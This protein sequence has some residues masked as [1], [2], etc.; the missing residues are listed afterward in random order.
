M[1]IAIFLTLKK[2]IKGKNFG[3]CLLLSILTSIISNLFM[4]LIAVFFITSVYQRRRLYQLVMKGGQLIIIK[5]FNKLKSQNKC[6]TTIGF[7]ICIIIWIICGY[8]VFTFVAV[9]QIQR[10]AWIL[11]FILSLFIDLL[12]GDREVSV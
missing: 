12:F 3:K 4:Y 2:N 6:S 8:I 11:T 10:S 9:W 1:L 7:I 5:A